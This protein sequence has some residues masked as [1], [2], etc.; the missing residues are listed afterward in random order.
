ML[1]FPEL[2]GSPYVLPA[3]IVVVVLILAVLFLMLRRRQRKPIVSD[4]LAETNDQLPEQAKRKPLEPARLSSPMATAAS[5][6]ILAMGAHAASSL[7]AADP[8]K[9]ALTRILEG[10]GD[11][12]PEDLSCLKVFRQEKVIAAIAALEI[13]QEVR[14][15]RYAQSR[16]SQLRAYALSLPEERVGEETAAPALTPDELAEV[17]ESAESAQV[18]MAIIDQLEHLATPAALDL[19]RRCLDDPDPQVQLHALDA[20]DRLLSARN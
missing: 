19:I 11:L 18:K 1:E 16:L 2:F 13:P 14:S 15:S 17:F 10:W 20:A 12:T 4:K 6:D 5:R 7:P 8:L 9:Q 3:I